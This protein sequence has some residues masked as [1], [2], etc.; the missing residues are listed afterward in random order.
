MTE[1][2][3]RLP[4]K[5]QAAIQKTTSDLENT[6]RGY[7][8]HCGGI[9]FYPAGVPKPLK[10]ANKRGTMSQITLNKHEIAKECQFKIDI[11]SS[12]ALS[13]LVEA[14]RLAGLKEP[15][16]F[17]AFVG[18]SAT[19]ELFRR[20][21]NIGITLAE[22]PLIRKAFQKIRPT[23]LEEVALC[24]AIIRP[25]AR[26]ARVATSEADL[27]AMFVY[28]DDAITLIANA[29][30]CTDAEADRYRRGFAKGDKEI[31]KKLK[32][33]LGSADSQQ[34]G[35]NVLDQLKNLRQYSFCKSHAFSYAQLV[36]QLGY[37][38]AHYPAEF[39]KATL[40]HNES[41]YRKWVHLYEAR[42]AGVGDL[43]AKPISIYAENRLKTKRAAART[44]EDQVRSVG[45]WSSEGFFPGC[46]L[47]TQGNTRVIRGLIASSRV[48]S[49]HSKVKKAVLTL[50]VG[51][52]Q[53]AEVVL[54]GP[55]IFLTKKIGISC[56]AELKGDVWVS[57]KFTVW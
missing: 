18:D 46:S 20:G 53:Y 41:S 5:Q 2:I 10:L 40:K 31:M 49:W 13:Q 36:W 22:S 42:C 4:L 15:L 43:G 56:T 32:T 57:Q 23:T 7:S 25:A 29:L 3:R 52:Q 45:I 19:A 33:A 11:L 21:D 34:T 8:L 14:R 26:E 30:G 35:I 12:R 48:L 54:E 47:V 37:M 1:T 50:G 51:S 9:V 39:W 17:E 24:L 16:D 28:D 38:K 27:T 44:P 6:F 55:R